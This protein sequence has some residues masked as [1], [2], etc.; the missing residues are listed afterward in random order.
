[1]KILDVNFAFGT[2]ARG[3]NDQLLN[4]IELQKLGHQVS[5]VTCDA[6]TFFADMQ[7]KAGN[8]KLTFQ[9][10]KPTEFYGI[11][12]FVL[13]CTIPKMG[14]YCS[15]ANR[16]AKKIVRNYDVVHVRNWYD[17]LSYV[18]SK[19]AYQHGVPYVMT[20]HGALDSES[21]KRYKRRTKWL[22]DHI[23]TKKA[24]VRAS[25]LH[26]TGESET[27]EFIKLGSNLQK[28]FRINPYVI[29]ENF[30]IKKRTNILERLGLDKINKPYIVF[31]SRVDPKKGIELLL[32][33]F[34]RL[35][36]KNLTLVIAG[37]GNK[38]YEQKLEQLVHDLKLENSVKFA[39]FV[40]GDDKLQLLESAKIFALTSY[41]DVHPVA[42]TEALMMGVPVLI[43]KNC[44]FPEVEEYNAGIIVE[45]NVESIYKG[46][47]NM[48]NDEDKLLVFSK[49]TKK[50]VVEQFLFEDKLKKYEEMYRYAIENKRVN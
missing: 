34:K 2:I 3:L 17:H 40:L 12:T 6:A 39:G 16:L 50:L 24:I 36:H 5:M 32:K 38:S 4:A 25:A 29:L 8:K 15:G 47:V 20:A 37:S 23:Y 46:L 48:I 35:N 28:I 30:E 31:L 1:M 18:F 7:K 22:I 11:P 49:N 42:I 45:A 10:D 21:R 33:S 14:W 13:H 26:S 44:D 43:T 27:R 41:S 9:E 19:T